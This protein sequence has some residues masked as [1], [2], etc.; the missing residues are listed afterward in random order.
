MKSSPLGLKPATAVWTAVFLLAVFSLPG[1]LAAAQP[2]V[3]VKIADLE[4]A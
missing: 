1:L 3:T 2:D 4:K